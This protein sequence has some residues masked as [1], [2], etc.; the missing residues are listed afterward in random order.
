MKTTLEKLRQRATSSSVKA[1]DGHYF[2]PDAKL[3]EIL[4]DTDVEVCIQECAGL[5]VA[6]KKD[7]SRTVKSGGRK[8]LLVL[9]QL[10]KVH[11]VLKFVDHN[12]A[13]DRQ[14]PFDLKGLE[15]MLADKSDA[16]SFHDKQWS[17]IPVR[18]E[19]GRTHR[20]Y[21]TRTIFPFLA[22]ES[23]KGA[24]GAF[25]EMSIVTV[26]GTQHEFLDLVDPRTKAGSKV[27]H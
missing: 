8:I 2:I 1:I 9:I 22:F 25:G 10:E 18:F 15:K 6:R 20:T 17:V 12:R 14:L 5:D 21:D 11:L 16:R 13:H 19:E 26:E 3:L 7:C 24:E 4:P 27:G 23:L